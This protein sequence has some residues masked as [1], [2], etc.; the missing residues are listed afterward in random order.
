[1]NAAQNVTLKISDNLDATKKQ[2]AAA[3]YKKQNTT[4]RIH[5]PSVICMRACACAGTTRAQNAWGVE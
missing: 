1:L 4:L 3:F 5:S 2:E